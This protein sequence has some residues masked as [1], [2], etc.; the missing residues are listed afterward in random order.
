MVQV[1]SFKQ[2]AP[3][4]R[5]KM[6]DFYFFGILKSLHSIIT[7]IKDLND[8]ETMLQSISLSSFLGPCL[9]YQCGTLLCEIAEKHLVTLET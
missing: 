9:L 1:L 6:K 5:P 2:S 3:S 7:S 8:R 4:E